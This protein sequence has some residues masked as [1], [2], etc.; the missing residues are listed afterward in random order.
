LSH[1]PPANSIAIVQQYLQPRK[2]RLSDLQHY[3]TGV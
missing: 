3:D 1:W 2:I